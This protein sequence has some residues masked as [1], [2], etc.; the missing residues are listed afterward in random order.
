MTFCHHNMTGESVD[1]H[2]TMT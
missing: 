2:V 1:H